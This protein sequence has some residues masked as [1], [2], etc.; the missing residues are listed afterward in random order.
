MPQCLRTLLRR[1]PEFIQP[2][3]CCFD[4]PCISHADTGDPANLA[5]YVLELA[6]KDPSHDGCCR[7]GISP[8]GDGTLQGGRQTLSFSQNLQNT[9]HRGQGIE[10]RPSRGRWPVPP[11]GLPEGLEGGRIDCLLARHCF[12]FTEAGRDHGVDRMLLD[13]PGGQLGDHTGADDRLGSSMG[14]PRQPTGQPPAMPR[15]GDRGCPAER[16]RPHGRTDAA[17]LGG[18][19]LTGRHKAPHRCLGGRAGPP[20]PWAGPWLADQ[21]RPAP[22]P[23]RWPPRDTPRPTAAVRC[24]PRSPRGASPLVPAAPPAPPTAP[25]RACSPPREPPA[26]RRPRRQRCPHGCAGALRQPHQGSV[27]PTTTH[28]LQSGT[29]LGTTKISI[30]PRAGAQLASASSRSCTSWTNG[31]LR[32]RESCRPTAKARRYPRRCR[33]TRPDQPP[34]AARHTPAQG[35]P[36]GRRPSTGR[37]GSPTGASCQHP[38]AAPSPGG[39]PRHSWGRPSEAGRHR[40]TRPAGL[41][42]RPRPWGRRP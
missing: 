26:H 35:R 25:P 12:G 28:H 41:C 20:H 18:V 38:G 34:G 30:T 16:Q 22:R 13:R 2:C 29:G 42:Q 9:P 40:R 24:H 37:P 27:G 10:R 14:G 3:R 5:F 7:I 4:Q 8:Q 36:G 17:A 6:A 1:S 21:E 31:S 32:Q 39:L 33:S 11:G 23:A 19:Q 15:R